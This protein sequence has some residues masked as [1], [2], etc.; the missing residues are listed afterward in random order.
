VGF[1][2]AEEWRELVAQYDHACAYCGAIGP[3]EQDHRLPLARGGT[4]WIGNIVP[5]CRV[6]N[7]RKHVM[8]E[9]EFRT[10]LDAEHDADQRARDLRNR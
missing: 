4:N 8:T 6:C 3:L 10:R 9:G 2:T 5:A 7:A 1:F